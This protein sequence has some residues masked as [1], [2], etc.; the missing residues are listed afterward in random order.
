MLVKSHAVASEYWYMF[1][2]VVPDPLARYILVPDGCH[3][4]VVAPEA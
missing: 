3:H 4:I 1:A 2:L